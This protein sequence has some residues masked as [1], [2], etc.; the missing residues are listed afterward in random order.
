MSRKLYLNHNLNISFFL[1]YLICCSCSTKKKEIISQYHCNNE[2]LFSDS[3]NLSTNKINKEFIT[4]REA[5]D[6]L[7]GVMKE[8]RIEIIALEGE[9]V[10]DKSTKTGKSTT[11]IRNITTSSVNEKDI[12]HYNMSWVYIPIIIALSILFFYLKFYYHRL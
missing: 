6:S 10:E 5:Y 8:K 7:S 4:I 3:M 11:A 9:K 2:V 1:L 12:P